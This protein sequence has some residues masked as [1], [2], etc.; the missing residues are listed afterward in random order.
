MKTS[1]I[2]LSEQALRHG[3]VQRAAR[4]LG[5]APSTVSDSIKRLEK[6]LSVKLIQSGTRGLTLTPEG[7]RTRAHLREARDLIHS[8]YAQFHSEPSEA[9]LAR[10]VSLIALFRFADIVETG[11]IR[12]SARRLQIGQPQLTRMMAALEETLGA[13]LFLRRRGG[14]TGTRDGLRIL[15]YV[16]DLRNVWTKLDQNSDDRFRRELRC[17]S[18]GGIPP[19]NHDSPTA[20][21]LGEFVA[22]WEEHYDTPLNLASAMSDMLLEGLN[23]QRY[24]AILVDSPVSAPELQSRLVSSS[25]LSFFIGG[26]EQ[27]ENWPEARDV[28]R[29]KIREGHMVLPSRG[30]GLRQS[31]EEFLNDLLGTEWQS[32]IRLTEIE[33]IPVA[34]NLVANHGFSTILPRSFRVGQSGVINLPLPDKYSLDLRLV[35]LNQTR[36]NQLSNRLLSILEQD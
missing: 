18:L 28:I 34:V 20:R 19:A 14:S 23:L 13:Q 8:I 10:P 31:S 7:M 24:D 30:S 2:L 16:E 27:P 6:A 25:S 36:G 29:R 35:W 22:R 5:V 17:W 4:A 33:S 21:I 1:T 12:K 11:S 15:R 3:G 32:E 9:A 26:D